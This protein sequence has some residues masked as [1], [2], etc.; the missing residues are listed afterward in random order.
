MAGTDLTSAAWRRTWTALTAVDALR[1][2]HAAN[3]VITHA[4][5]VLYA[6]AADHHDGVLLEVVTLARD[7]ADHFEAIGE[8]D[9]GDL[10]KGRVRLLRSRRIHAGAHATLLRA[11]FHVARLLAVGLKASRGFRINC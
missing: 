1:V 2:E 9:L 4:G 6:A 10:A 3:D 5:K 8:A 11:G 7:I